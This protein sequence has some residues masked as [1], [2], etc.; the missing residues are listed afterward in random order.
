[1]QPAHTLLWYDLETFGTHTQ[2]DR[3]AQFAA[4]RTNMDLEIVQE[5]MV[6]YC[7]I[8]PDYLPDPLA[9]LL[10][11]ITPQDTLEKG[12]PEKE[13][14][15]RV[16]TEFSR[17]NTCVVGYNNI[18]FD[19]ELVR[20]ALYRNFYDPYVREYANGNSRWDVM[21]MLRAAH[22]LRPDGIT[23]PR[24]EKDRPSF[25]LEHLT[26]ANNISHEDAHDALA[27]V[28]ATISVA[29][30]VKQHQPNLYNY[31]FSHRLK[32]TLKGEIDMHKQT[33][34]LHTAGSHTTEHGC[35]ALLMPLAADPH[36]SN[37][38][39][40]FDLSHDPEELIHA[41]TEDLSSHFMLTKVSLNKCPFISPLSIFTDEVADRL[42]IDKE[43]C[44]KNYKRL[45]ERPDVIGK[46]HAF[47]GAPYQEASNDPDFQIYS[48]G[49]FNDDDKERFSIIHRADPGD[50]LQLN[51]RF[52]DKRIAEMLWR[53][54]CRNYPEALSPEEKRKWDNFCAS[55]LLF[56]PG[57][58]MI[59]YQFYTRK[60]REKAESKET[61]GEQ[62]LI[63]KALEEYGK[64][65][66]DA[67]IITR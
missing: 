34:F 28:Y 38:V 43:L 16:F 65:V 46:I 62:K 57:D 8:T 20:N 48:G 7:R 9:C 51:L 12:L 63:L 4:I 18:S 33:P 47:Y 13:F 31:A 50:L 30:L 6:L 66:H 27:D 42:H 35:S 19:D 15:D 37:A 67:V 17:P 44:R 3:I 22:D 2:Y 49:F 53:Y 24:N 55:R 11:G 56:P 39:Y 61:T 54:T 32:R 1:M 26:K 41:K 23:W 25:K 60:I 21:D 52:E 64:Q 36:N 14:I 29:R 45:R 40:C 10:T 59:S 5:P 58:I